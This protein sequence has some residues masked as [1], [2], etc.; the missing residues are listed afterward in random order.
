MF[1]EEK[2]RYTWRLKKCATRQ[3]VAR[4][5]PDGVIGIFYWR[6]SSSRIMNLE[7]TLPLIEMRDK[8]G[9]CVG[10]TTLP[11]SCADILEIWEVQTLGTL[12]ACPGL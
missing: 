5:I 3:K 8:G 2:E 6:N 12:R 9:H 1:Q 7:S 4:S 11:T 10:M